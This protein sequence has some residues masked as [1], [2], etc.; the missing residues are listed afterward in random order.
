MGVK[1]NCA[2]GRA[3]VLLALRPRNGHG[4]RKSAEKQGAS[5]IRVGDLASPA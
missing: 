4:K 1:N 3:V 5:L 2:A